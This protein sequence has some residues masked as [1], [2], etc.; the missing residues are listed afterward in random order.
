MNELI[1]CVALAAVF[2]PFGSRV[3]HNPANHPPKNAFLYRGYDSGD[4]LVIKGWL[5]FVVEDATDVVG[6]WCLDRVGDPDDIGPQVGVGSLRGRAEGP[7]LSLNLNPGFADFHVLLNGALDGTSFKGTWRY[8]TVRGP[9]S[10]GTFE[11]AQTALPG[12]PREPDR[13]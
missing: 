4:R 7:R 3:K 2:G 10:E 13:D 1:V 8:S 12:T 6:E 11:A 5:R 9:V